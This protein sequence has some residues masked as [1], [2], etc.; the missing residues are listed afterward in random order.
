MRLSKLALNNGAH[1]AGASASA[2]GDASVTDDVVVSALG[3]SAHG[4]GVSASAAADASVGNNICHEKYTSN[5]MYL[6][7]ITTFKKCNAKFLN[8][9][10][11]EKKKFL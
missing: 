4:A 10:H 1:G 7:S 2:A 11:A 8:F 9:G 6:H 3:D 5:R